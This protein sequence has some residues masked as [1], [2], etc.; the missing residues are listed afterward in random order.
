MTSEQVNLLKKMVDEDNQ[1]FVT[2]NVEPHCWNN[3]VEWYCHF[4]L[5]EYDI[6][7]EDEFGRIVKYAKAVDGHWQLGVMS[8]G[9]WGERE[10]PY[11]TID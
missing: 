4:Y 11:F 2:M 7:D 8:R 9:I 10:K 3:R 5:P 1:R 6:L